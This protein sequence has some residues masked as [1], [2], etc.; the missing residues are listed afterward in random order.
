MPPLAIRWQNFRSFCDSGWIDLRRITVFL[1]ANASG[2]TS[3]LAPLLLLKQT[4]ESRDPALALKTKGRLFN[5]GSFEDLIHTHKQDLQLRFALRFGE[6][7][8]DGDHNKEVGSHPP[9][10]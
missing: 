1:G 4:N 7:T 5:A 9:A 6:V 2:K 10:E 3:L 8:P